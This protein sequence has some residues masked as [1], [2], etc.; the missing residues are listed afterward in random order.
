[1]RRSTQEAPGQKSRVIFAGTLESGKLGKAFS[2]PKMKEITRQPR[3]KRGRAKREREEGE[4]KRKYL[5][6]SQGWVSRV[7]KS[8]SGVMCFRVY[9]YK[10]LAWK[11]G[12][13]LYH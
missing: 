12:E 1:M 5:L 11:S 13:V 8:G 9:S 10:E 4:S 7:Q 2:S 3:V 6:Y